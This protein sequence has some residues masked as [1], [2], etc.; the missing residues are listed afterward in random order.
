MVTA[1]I[2]LRTDSPPKPLIRIKS[3][4]VTGEPTKSDSTGIG[5]L[6]NLTIGL[7]GSMILLISPS[8]PPKKSLKNSPRFNR[9]SRN[10]IVGLGKF[11]R[12]CTSGKP[13]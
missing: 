6:K 11:L 4:G 7:T 1:S 3:V 10:S 9:V 2:N 8:A 12:S 5:S 13:Q